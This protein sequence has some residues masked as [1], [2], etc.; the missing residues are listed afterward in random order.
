MIFKNRE[1]YDAAEI[2]Q[3]IE[4]KQVS[5]K[6]EIKT[7]K[8]QQTTYIF[9]TLQQFLR[10][11][12]QGDFFARKMSKLKFIAEILSQVMDILPSIDGTHTNW[13]LA[14]TASKFRKC[15][16]N[17]MNSG[18]NRPDFVVQNYVGYELFALEVAG[19]PTHN[20]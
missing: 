17:N 11:F 10:K 16:N 5:K 6:L 2:Y 18:R 14:S 8:D 12:R 3:I 20:D 7:L 1:A 19:G 15:Q 13:N 9:K 4:E